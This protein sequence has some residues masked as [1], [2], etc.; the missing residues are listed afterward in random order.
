[1]RPGDM[2]SCNENI[3]FNRNMHIFRFYMNQLN[4][5]MVGLKSLKVID[6][7]TFLFITNLYLAGITHGSDAFKVARSDRIIFY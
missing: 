6:M 3:L 5:Y 7:K 2:V 4:Y 1:M